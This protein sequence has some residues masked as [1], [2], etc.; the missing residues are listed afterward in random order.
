MRHKNEEGECVRLSVCTC[1]VAQINAI[2]YM[3]IDDVYVY[4]GLTG[5]HIQRIIFD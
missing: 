3:P 5:W 1:V 4:V 2:M